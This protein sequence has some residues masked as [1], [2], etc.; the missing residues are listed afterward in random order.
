MALPLYVLLPNHYARAYG[1]PL[2]TLGAVLL[3]ARLLDAATDPLLGRLSDRPVRPLHPHRAGCGG[4]VGR[5][6]GAGHVRAVLPARAGRSRPWP[7]G[8]CCACWPPTWPT[9]S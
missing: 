5:G 4:R 6:A 3:A 2:A 9:A 1:M 8:R 7:G